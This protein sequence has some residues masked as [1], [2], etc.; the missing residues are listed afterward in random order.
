MTPPRHHPSA[1]PTLLMNDPV[2]RTL[3][4]DHDDAR[5]R[6]LMATPLCRRNESV[7]RLLREKLDRCRVVPAARMPASIVTMN[8]QIA[9]WGDGGVAREL[10]LVY[11]WIGAPASGRVSVL[12]RLGIELL[13]AIPGHVFRIDGVSFSIAYVSYQPEAERQFHL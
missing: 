2:T 3:V 8:S 10:A 7:T 12:S 5:L 13:G 6:G 11:P 1:L 4:T 9:C